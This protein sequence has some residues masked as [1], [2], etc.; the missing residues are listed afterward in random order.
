[1][2]YIIIYRQANKMYMDTKFFGPYD[3]F[4]D[5]Y[6]ELVKLPVCG[7]VD[8]DCAT[9]DPGVKYIEPIYESVD[10]LQRSKFEGHGICNAWSRN[11]SQTKTK[12]K[13]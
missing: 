13:S 2:K 8:K 12:T 11:R 7:S 3:S 9:P 4:D 5:A 6:R 10:P 1:M